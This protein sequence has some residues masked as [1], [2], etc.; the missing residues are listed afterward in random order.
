MAAGVFAATDPETA[1]RAVF[2]ATGRFHDPCHAPE[3]ARPEAAADFAAV[4][5]LVV[6]GLRA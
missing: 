6:R 5:E 3:W 1:A 2:H 4:V